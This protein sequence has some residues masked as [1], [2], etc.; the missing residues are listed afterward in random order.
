M[1]PPPPAERILVRCPNWLGDVVMATPGLR[2]LRRT[3]PDAWIVGQL[4]EPL[5]PLLEG[6]GYCD[7]L[8]PVAPRRASF[9][10][11]RA[12]ARR[13]A[14]VSFDLG[15]LVPESISSVLRM[16]WGRVGRII[17]FARDPLR[18]LMLDDVVSAPR[19]WGRRRLVSR[20]RFVL[21]LMDAVGAA[22]DDVK[23]GLCVT[24]E[25]RARL[26]EALIETGL[27]IAD[28]AEDPPI[29]MAP[30]ASFGPSKCWPTDSYAELA[31]L[32]AERG[33]CVILV[34]GIGE[35]SRLE[36]V[37]SAMRSKPVVL[38]AALDLG[39]L[40]ALIR[41]ARL[42][43]A[44]DAGT[45][46]IAAAFGIPSIVFFGPTS[47]E[48]TADNLDA[49][50]ILE[51]EHACRPCYRRNCPIDHRCLRSIAVAEADSAAFRVL[52][53]RQSPK[54]DPPVYREIG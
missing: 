11:L 4:P 9:S 43:V 35:H 19:Q 44:N 24:D 21:A 53:R 50:E 31:D 7:E 51:T 49:I 13:L 10:V 8:W 15:I 16:R 37:R 25:E 34:G 18:R 38:D 32:F 1:T 39:S 41:A 14:K 26:D 47:V 2:A 29:V 20:E 33:Q 54:L 42:L 48:K 45:R 23:L 12:E 22:S 3:Y 30:G 27:C 36:A 46:H 52:A 5:L 40:K 28:F 6:T 17:G